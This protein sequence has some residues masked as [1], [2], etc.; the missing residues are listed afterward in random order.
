M[1]KLKLRIAKFECALVMQV[2]EM[3]NIDFS[4]SSHVLRGRTDFAQ[5]CIYLRKEPSIGLASFPDNAERDAYLQKMLGWITEEQFGGARKLE[6][7]KPCLIRDCEDEEWAER[8]YA[9][10]VAKQLGMCKRH[11]ACSESEEDSFFRWRYAK[12]I[13][14]S[15]KIDGEIYTWETEE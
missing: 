4:V 15:L 3:Q 10:K 11:L 9:G 14:D 6:I 12:P 7:G 8:I 5:E 1:K 2:L 13:N